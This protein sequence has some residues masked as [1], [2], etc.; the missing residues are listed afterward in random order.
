MIG[1]QYGRALPRQ[2]ASKN[3][4][5][6]GTILRTKGEK[7]NDTILDSRSYRRSDAQ[8]VEGT[9]DAPLDHHT[10]ERPSLLGNSTVPCGVSRHHAG[11]ATG[12]SRT[13]GF[14]TIGRLIRAESTPNSADSH[15]IAV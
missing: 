1:T 3:T 15:Q 14:S 12:A 4:I 13:T 2:A 5:Y 8:V 11:C 6:A 10:D 7:S 9:S